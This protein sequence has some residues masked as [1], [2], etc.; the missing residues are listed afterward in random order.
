MFKEIMYKN[1]FMFEQFI[2]LYV[3]FYDMVCKT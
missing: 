2:D 3:V 1:S